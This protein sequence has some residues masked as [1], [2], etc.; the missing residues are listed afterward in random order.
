MNTP[1]SITGMSDNHGAALA[2]AGIAPSRD[3][4]KEFQEAA[5]R[6]K[7]II[8]TSIKSDI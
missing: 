4:T 2:G 3:G 6:G 1:C 5:A 8:K 7:P